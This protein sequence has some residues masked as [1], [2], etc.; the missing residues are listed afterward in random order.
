MRK[1]Y[2]AALL[3]LLSIIAFTIQPAP[4]ASALDG[5]P[6]SVAFEFLPADDA[7]FPG[8][9]FQVEFAVANTIVSGDYVY[10]SL[11]YMEKV[12]NISAYFSWM[13]VGD[14]VWN[15]V[16]ATS[17]WLEPD[18]VGTGTYTIDVDIPA[19]ATD[20]TYSYFFEI[21]YLA[22]TAWGN[23]TY[24]WGTGTT[25]HDLVV[26]TQ[27]STSPAYIALF[28]PEQLTPGVELTMTVNLTNCVPG[29][30]ALD[31]CFSIMPLWAEPH[32]SWMGPGDVVRTDLS[33]GSSWLQPGDDD[34]HVFTVDYQVPEDIEPGVYTFY[35]EIGYLEDTPWGESEMTVQ[36]A[37]ESLTVA[38]NGTTDDNPPDGLALLISTLALVAAGA[39][40]IVIYTMWSR[41]RLIP[42][43]AGGNYPRIKPLPGQKVDVEP[44]TVYLVK[45]DRPRLAFAMFRDAV[46][47]GAAGMLVS[48][49]HP[50]KL[51]EIY[52]FKAETAFWLSKRAD[53]YHLDPT[54]L[55]LLSLK[56]GKL[57][58]EKGKV[59]V[60]IEGVEYLITQNDFDAVLRFVNHMHEF[61]SLHDCSVIFVVDP[62]ILETRQLALLERSARVVEP[63]EEEAPEKAPP[64][65]PAEGAA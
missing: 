16:S 1:L 59:V 20:Q 50:L 61:V 3:G 37:A 12:M 58:E 8:E 64:S 35:L 31:D 28:Q 63:A 54:E 36:G 18:G 32:F 45:E 38:S 41:G 24:Y 46:D 49:E 27:T 4:S 9:P 5:A 57:V 14:Y 62:R 30:S 53:K 34:F 44:S 7:Y 26:S 40:G 60:L 39:A 2:T 10:D 55:S 6:I 33:D 52:G 47:A 29:G 51:E 19:T 22:H 23:V 17:S 56:I 21:E 15:N 65:A 11:A 13:G 25:Y 43:F 42:V 48:R